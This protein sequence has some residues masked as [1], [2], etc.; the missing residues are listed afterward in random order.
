MKKVILSG[1]L[2]HRLIKL[3]HYIVD[4]RPKRENPRES[5]FVFYADEWF[6]QD[7]TYCMQNKGGEDAILQDRLKAL[8]I[9]EKEYR[10]LIASKGI[11]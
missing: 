4:V 1:G 7:V 10:L 6:A 3:G 8:G 9:S 11:G 2:A 5:S